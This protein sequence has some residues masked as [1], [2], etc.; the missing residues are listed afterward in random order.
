MP[1]VLNSASDGLLISISFSSFW[2]FDLSF[3]LGHV[4][5]S[6]HFGSLPVFLCLFLC[7]RQSCYDSL[8]AWPN[9]VGVL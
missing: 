2:S 1:S 5:L 8:V 4:S 6:P 7:V 9:V 3:H